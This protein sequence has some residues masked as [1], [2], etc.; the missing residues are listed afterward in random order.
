MDFSNL[1]NP[2]ALL[3]LATLLAAG[4][5]L[6][7]AALTLFTLASLRHPRRRTYAYAVARN[8][9]G[10]PDELDTPAKF[11]SV[12]VQRQHKKREHIDAWAIMGD[13]PRGPA[14][15][16]THGWGSCRIDMLSRFQALRPFA[17]RV[18]LW[19]MPAH[20][21]TKGPCTLGAREPADLALVIQRAARKPG[22]E[23]TP[24]VLYG[25]SLGAEVTLKAMNRLD[26]FGIDQTDIAGVILEAPYRRGIT[27]AKAVMDASEFPRLLNLPLAMVAGSIINRTAPNERWHD[28]ATHNAAPLATARNG[29]P[30]PLLVIHGQHDTISPRED[31][32]AIAHAARGTLAEIDDAGH[33][34]LFPPNT[35]TRPEIKHALSAFFDTLA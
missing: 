5:A 8:I 4:A 29:N 21:D 9:P 14:I 6:Y 11:E 23:T 19:D 24:I 35:P 1:T 12:T 34:D 3:G 33:K 18:V 10:D 30:I 7:F 31:G 15:L 22:D 16:A 25:Y 32:E 20:G 27:P 26:R 17:S 2:S 28:L 13:N